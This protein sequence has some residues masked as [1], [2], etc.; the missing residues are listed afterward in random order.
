LTYAEA[1]AEQG[2]LTQSDLDNSVNLIRV[3]AGMPALSLATANASADPVQSAKYPDVSGGNQGVILEIRRERRV[4]MALE[5]Y[6][7]DDLM[8]WHG[9]SLMAV[10]PEGMYFPGLGQYDMTG[11]GIADIILIDANTNIPDDNNKITNSLGKTLVYYNAGSFGDNVT[12]YL[13]NGASGGGT[14]VTEITPRHFIDPKY[15]YRPIPYQQ[16]VLNSNLTQIFGW[17]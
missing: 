3:R 10:I 5:G 8:R 16:T 13:R 9:G 7:Y 14:L 1:A 6:R 15:Y 2:T 4:E 11:D 12:V 17:D